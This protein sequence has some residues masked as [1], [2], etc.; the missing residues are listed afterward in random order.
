GD[1]TYGSVFEMFPFD[2]R[3]VILDLSGADLRK[4]IARQ[5]HNPRRRAGFSGMRVFVAC[6]AKKMT[7]RMQSDNGQMIDDRDRI[8]VGVN[9][10]LTSG[11]DGIL[12]P[13][14]P[15]AGFEYENDVRLTRDVVA[16]WLRQR[17]G[18]L[19]A[20]QFVDT[21]APRWTVSENLSESCHL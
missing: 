7:V 9:D 10:F 2:N 12:T 19:H 15:E 18:S 5:A 13:A 6:D 11:G 4:I 21:E 20:G 17:G 3:V 1:L 14:T 8:R 16:N